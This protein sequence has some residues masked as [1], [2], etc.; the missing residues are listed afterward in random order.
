MHM[1]YKN[2]HTLNF[3]EN[4]SPSFQLLLPLHTEHFIEQSIASC[5]YLLLCLYSFK[6]QTCYPGHTHQLSGLYV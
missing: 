2:V 4:A 6:V 5:F 3:I 1:L